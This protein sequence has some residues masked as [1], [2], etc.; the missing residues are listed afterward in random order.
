MFPP[1]I[2]FLAR[3]LADQS[4]AGGR[5]FE[6]RSSPIAVVITDRFRIRFAKS[7]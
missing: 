5:E 2:G 6:A 7:M 3:N 1:W 4:V